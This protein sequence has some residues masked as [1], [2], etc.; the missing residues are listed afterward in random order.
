MK[1]NKC[2]SRIIFP[3][4]KTKWYLLII[5]HS[6]WGRVLYKPIFSPANKHFPAFYGIQ[7]SITVLKRPVIC[8]CSQ[9]DY[10]TSY[11]ISNIFSFH[12]YL[13]LANLLFPLGF[14][15]KILYAF[16]L[17]AIPPTSP[18]HIT[19]RSLSRYNVNPLCCFNS[20]CQSLL[21]QSS[22]H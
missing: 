2:N 18:S 4:T 6:P 15:I 1:C 16:L 7:I 22:T 10:M 9:T 20:H 5:H 12:L 13:R 14:G 8:F 17:S 19:A 21:L 3:V 11:H